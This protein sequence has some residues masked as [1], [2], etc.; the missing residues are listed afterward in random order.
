MSNKVFYG[1]LLLIVG[2]GITVVAINREPETQRPGTEQA[3]K[4]REHV[5][6]KEYGGEEP[7][8]SGDHAQP[9]PW[10]VYKQEVPDDS[11][12]HNMEHGGVYISYR[13]DL[14]ADQVE[15]IE[16][17][18]GEPFSR[19]GFKPIKAVVAPRSANSSPIIMSSW[20]R[21]LKLENFDEQ[22]MVDYYL[23]NIG[24]SPEPTAS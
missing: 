5:E 14:P 2:L 8:T 22:V 4:G 18:F 19:E 16:K 3:N 24:K 21:N 13:P 9:V 17:L 10:Q 23:N 1:I 7:P 15:N 6:S 20:D 11:T 12:I